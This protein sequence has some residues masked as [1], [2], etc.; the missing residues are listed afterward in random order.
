M[1]HQCFFSMLATSCLLH[2]VLAYESIRPFTYADNWGWMS[3]VQRLHFKAYMDMLSVTSAM[4]LSIDH[5]KSWH[6]GTKK[7]REACSHIELFHPDGLVQ[8]RV[9]TAVKDLGE[10]ASYNRCASSGFIKEKIDEAVTR[11]HRLE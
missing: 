6:W 10:S 8:V 11:L 5:S 7:F 9:K 3:K 1:Q 2:D 4:R